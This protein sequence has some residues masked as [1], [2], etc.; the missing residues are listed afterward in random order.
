MFKIDC[1]CVVLKRQSSQSNVFM[2]LSEQKNVRSII[3]VICD[4]FVVDFPN[5]VLPGP[6]EPSHEFTTRIISARKPSAHSFP[7]QLTESAFNQDM[8]G[9]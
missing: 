3:V 8:D 4:G 2:F 9:F 1:Q 6:P 5:G 7:P